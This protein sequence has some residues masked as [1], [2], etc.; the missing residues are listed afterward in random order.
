MFHTSFYTVPIPGLMELW[1]RTWSRFVN[2]ESRGLF[3]HNR[4]KW[5]SARGEREKERWVARFYPVHVFS[6]F[7][8]ICCIA[9]NFVKFRSLGGKKISPSFPLVWKYARNFPI[10]FLK[11]LKRFW[12][13]DRRRNIRRGIFF[14]FY[15]YFVR[16][17][18]KVRGHPWNEYYS[19]HVALAHRNNYHYRNTSDV[20]FPVGA[21]PQK[22]S[23]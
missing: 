22:I 5:E 20:S 18:E 15:L 12:I 9:A 3:F 16:F 4:G 13:F 11:C 7:T 8:M 10:W 1:G 17:C 23:L 6:R 2:P 14:F 21:N 19:K